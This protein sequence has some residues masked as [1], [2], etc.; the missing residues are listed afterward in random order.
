MTIFPGVFHAGKNL[1]LSL[2]PAVGNTGRSIFMTK[3]FA[4]ELDQ[5]YLT[6]EEV[7]L[8]FRVSPSTVKNWREAGLLSYFQ[9]LGSTRV[10]YPREAVEEFEKQHTRRAKILEFRRPAEVKKGKPGV[11]SKP[12]KEWRI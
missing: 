11:S 6:Q 4:Y 12:Q 3:E 2:V 8:L 10:L 5:K 7:A 1:C 9:P